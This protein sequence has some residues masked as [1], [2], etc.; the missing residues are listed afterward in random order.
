[1]A[2]ESVGVYLH[3]PFCERICPYCDFA[4]V[5]A[6]T[7]EEAVEERC[8]LALLR[9]LESRAGDFAGHVL[10]SV[11]LGGGT[12]SLLRPESIARLVAAARERFG[13][14]PSAPSETAVEITLEVNPST[15]ERGR[16]GGFREAGVNR[17]SVGVQSFD[18]ET[19]R[20]L[21][22]AH[23]AG[24]AHAT[25]RAAREAGFD[26]ISLDLIF[27]APGQGLSQVE[28]DLRATLE[29]G[30]EHVSTYALTLEEG[31]PFERAVAGGRLQ[32]PDDDLAAE[33]METLR[34][35]LEEGGLPSYE[36]SSHARPGHEAVHNRRYWSR[37]PVLGVGVGA[38]SV[39]PRSPATPH[40]ARRANERGYA[41]WLARV[42]A[43][44]PPPEGS[45]EILDLET[46]RGE[47]FL[48]ALRTRA[49]VDA[50]AF[51]AEFGAPPR[52]FREPAIAR[53][54]AAGLLLES[55]AGDLRLSER[56]VLLA[57]TV[58]A[59]LVSDGPR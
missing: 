17:L 9:E 15:L 27:A 13:S 29:F 57:D 45:L 16:L 5:A 38:W 11:Y 39:E 14:S 6:R 37:E 49:G 1:M 19:L 8:V 47:A 4:V 53:A 3:V 55:P 28:A 36:I 33:M 2:D 32:V 59:S 10:A 41:E 23:R 40:G 24:E 25:L 31:T 12:P 50:G 51:E 21:G 43:G 34:R 30:P 20:R 54:V 7:L 22:R 42:E 46:A 58:L 56:G 26:E 35:G 44:Q 48:L 52:A 18:D